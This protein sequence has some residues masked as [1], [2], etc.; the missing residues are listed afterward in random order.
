M[1]YCFIRRDDE[2]EIVTVLL[3]R[4]RYSRAIQVWVVER[5]GPNL[6]AADVAQRVLM[7]LRNFGHRGRVFIK[8]D[9]EPAILTFKEEMMRR[10]EVGA[11]V[12]ESAPDESESN[13]SLENGVKLFR[14]MIQVQLLVLEHNLKG[15]IPSQHPAMIWLVECVADIVTKY[16]QGA[17]GA[18]ARRG[19]G[20]W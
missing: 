14:S 5:K 12:V 2:I 9:N 10:F 3:M 16:M 8:T 20:V 11:I 7:G 19:F 4:D 17:D 1:D 15:N 6:D 18:G 13:G